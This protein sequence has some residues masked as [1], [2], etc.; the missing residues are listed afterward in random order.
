M[1]ASRGNTGSRGAGVI[2]RRS[3]LALVGAALMP[4]VVARRP[5]S[6]PA[7]QDH[8]AVRAGRVGRHH[9]APDRQADRGENQTGGRHRQPPRRQRHHRHHGGE[10]RRARRL[11]GAADHHQHPCRQCQPRAQSVLRSCQGF[12]RGRRVSFQRQLPDGAAAGAVARSCRLHRRRQG[13]AR[14]THLRLLQCLLAH[15]AGVSRQAR[16]DRAAGRALS[17]DRKCGGGFD[18]R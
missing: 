9:R 12:H 13:R 15:A 7:D 1:S 4:S 2:D 11:H 14:Q 16:R 10:D 5:I 6:V 17:R 3:V 8:R 18:Q